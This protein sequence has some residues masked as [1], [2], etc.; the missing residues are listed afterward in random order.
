VTS[1]YNEIDPHA[2]AW[3]REL[4]KRGL[5]AP[6]DVDERSIED[7]LPADLA[8]YTQCHFFAGIGGWAYAL[9]LA[10]W[11]RDRP[12]WTGSCPCQPFS[13]AG[14]GL[15]FADE[16]HLWPAFFHLIR[17]CAPA[18][19]IGEQV[20]S[21]DGLRWWDV[22]RTDLE[23]AGYACGA[24]DLCS[25]WASDDNLRQRLYWLADAAGE[26]HDG[27]DALLRPQG[28]G[29]NSSAILEAAWCGEAGVAQGDASSPGLAQ[30]VGDGRV[31]REAV[32]SLAGQ[33]VIGAGDLGGLGDAQLSAVARFREHC[34]TVVSEQE[35]TR[36][37][38][39]RRLGRLARPVEWVAC[40]DGDYRPIEPGSFPLVDDVPARVVR[41]RGYG[42]AI[43]PE[44]AATFVRAYCEAREEM[45]AAA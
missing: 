37:G 44:V 15:G 38:L 21:E 12:V 1:Y 17:Q 9:D 36:L 5:I 41:L 25:A 18:I 22:V 2:A 24:S 30:R 34:G 23:G 45:R 39:P 11:P 4:I 33:A 31:Q 10:G 13:A 7:V 35:A 3:L 28:A 32:G 29:R 14:K 26:R 43:N 40:G 6:G 27:L 20:A 16:R 42:N 8:G 19:V